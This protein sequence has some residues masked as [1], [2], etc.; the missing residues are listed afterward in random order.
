ME[1]DPV[2]IDTVNNTIYELPGL[3]LFSH[4]NTIHVH[5]FYGN[6]NIEQNLVIELNYFVWLR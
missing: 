1:D 4:E 2:V 5:Y 6:S 3:G